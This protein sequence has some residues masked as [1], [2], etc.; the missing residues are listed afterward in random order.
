MVGY[1]RHRENRLKTTQCRE[2]G[3]GHEFP[4]DYRI[5]QII[6]ICKGL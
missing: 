6:K 4:L 2:S 3:G 5:Y 1:G